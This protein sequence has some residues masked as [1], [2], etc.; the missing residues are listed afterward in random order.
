MF[1]PVP[2]LVRLLLVAAALHAVPSCMTVVGINSA[3]TIN[4]SLAAGAK[5]GSPFDA[6][7]VGIADDVTIIGGVVAVRIQVATAF[8]DILM[9]HSAALRVTPA[10]V[11]IS[12]VAAIDVVAFGGRTIGG[13]HDGRPG[14]RVLHACGVLCLYKARRS[15]MPATTAATASLLAKSK[16]TVFQTMLVTERGFEEKVSAVRVIKE[17][18]FAERYFVERC[19]TT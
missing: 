11:L 8:T 3:V 2:P 15:S 17:R 9:I 14:C 1:R 12:N 10:G 18:I 7:L 13:H 5:G 6:V 4:T 19:L 16:R